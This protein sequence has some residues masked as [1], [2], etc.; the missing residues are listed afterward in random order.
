MVPTADA[1]RG[2]PA[3]AQEGLKLVQAAAVLGALA[4]SVS[5][6][7]ARLWDRDTL[8]QV[9]EAG[10][11]KAFILGAITGRFDKLGRSDDAI[12]SSP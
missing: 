9:I 3:W 1:Y 4:V 12:E 7:T 5:V 10:E 8:K 6:A 11:N 2:L